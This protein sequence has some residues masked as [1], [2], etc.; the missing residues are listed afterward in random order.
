MLP[1]PTVMEMWDKMENKIL[2]NE[3]GHKLVRK[4]QKARPN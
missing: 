1:T 4:W 3:Y 2:N